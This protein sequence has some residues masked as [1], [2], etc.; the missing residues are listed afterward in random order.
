MSSTSVVAHCL[1]YAVYMYTRVRARA[2]QLAVASVFSEIEK[3]HAL[4]SLPTHLP[5]LVLLSRMPCLLASLALPRR[6]CRRFPGARF[7]SRLFVYI[8]VCVYVGMHVRGR[9]K[10]GFALKSMR[11]VDYFQV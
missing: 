9:R 6:Q 1:C 10:K 8:Y 7:H 11:R 2:R 5:P 4:L 3:T